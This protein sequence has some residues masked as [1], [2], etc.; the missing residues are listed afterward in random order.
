MGTGRMADGHQDE[1]ARAYARQQLGSLA[2]TSYAALVLT[3]DL[4]TESGKGNRLRPASCAHASLCARLANQFA[5]TA[6]RLPQV[7]S[8]P[9][10]TRQ[11]GDIL[12]SLATLDVEPHTLS[13]RPSRSC[14]VRIGDFLEV[15]CVGIGVVC[16]MSAASTRPV[17]VW[18]PAACRH[19][20]TTASAPLPSSSSLLVIHPGWNTA[21]GALLRDHPPRLPSAG[22]AHGDY[23]LVT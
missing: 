14:H 23:I 3:A 11:K 4:A 20:G 17:T 8:E 22:L 12:P 10:H 5:T 18:S 15:R 9:T 2:G 16:P 1:E 7:K 21:A 19:R 13:S 6:R